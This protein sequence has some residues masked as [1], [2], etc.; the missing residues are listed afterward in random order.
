MALSPSLQRPL[1]PEFRFAGFDFPRYVGMLPRG[2]LA[3]RL[4]EAR[5]RLCGP[6]Y[7]APRPN[8]TDT[9]FYLESDFM[10]GLRWRW[11]DDVNARIEHTG[12]FCDQHQHDTVRGLVMTLPGNRGF[13]AGWSMGES[14]AS[15]VEQHV[16]ADEIAAS[17]AADSLAERVAERNV[18]EALENDQAEEGE[19]VDA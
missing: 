10:P 17:W 8:G 18:E 4:Q 7:H 3:R 16:Y 1:Q 5:N 11:C 19:H 13:L 9:P 6:Y 15:S 12:W 2:S 14:M